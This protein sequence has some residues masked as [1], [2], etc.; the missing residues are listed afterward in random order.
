MIYKKII[1]LNYK[2]FTLLSFFISYFFILGTVIINYIVDPFQIY[3]A[4]SFYTFKMDEQRYLNA[5]LLKSYPFNTI[6]TGSSMVENFNT[7]EIEKILQVQNASKLPIQGASGFEL[8]TTINRALKYQDIKTIF[9]GLDIYSFSNDTAYYKIPSIF[10]EYLYDDNIFN[11]LRYLL[12]YK[13]LKK[14]L[15]A[16]KSPYNKTAITKKLETIYSWG[17]LFKG[18]FNK[19]ETQKH[20]IKELNK[21]NLKSTLEKEKIQ[22]AFSISILKKNFD[23][24]LQ[25]IV[26]NNPSIK[27]YIFF[28]PYSS[29]AFKLMQKQNTLNDV[30]LF[31]KYISEQLKPYKNVHL[32][33]FQL[34]SDI[35]QNLDNYKDITHYNQEINYWLLLQIQNDLYRI[36]PD[37][38]DE[39]L[40]AFQ[41][42]IICFPT[43]I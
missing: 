27:F 41:Q 17:E 24:Y 2:K 11:D 5:G 23:T 10:P 1:K 33:D 29:L 35:T 26:I 28:P 32:Y 30:I 22:S 8:Y 6:I 7:P 4:A 21:Y 31:K 43:P 25:T 34:A 36:N 13:I 16:I 9:L 37:F 19:E 18:L 40:K 12:N 39:Q 3:R 42:E 15:Q 20:F 14:S 38:Y